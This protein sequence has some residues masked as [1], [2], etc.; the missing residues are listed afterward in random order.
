[1]ENLECD[2]GYM[3]SG[4]AIRGAIKKYGRE[5]FK[6]EL[7]VYFNTLEEAYE[8]EAMI[9]NEFFITRKDTYNMKCGGL[10][11]G[12]AG[13]NSPRYGK[14]HSDETKQK[15]S[16]AKK[17]KSLS[18]ETKAKMSEAKTGE[19]HPFF[20]KTHSDKTKQKISK[21]KKGVALPEEHKA[22]VVARAKNDP[23]RALS[24]LVLKDGVIIKVKNLRRFCREKGIAYYSNFFRKTEM[25]GYTLIGK[26]M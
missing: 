11:G 15:I 10:G 17:G 1:M 22:K 23:N 19:K 8:V 6:K 2:D 21:A 4:N 14:H 18:E 20:G 24:W 26:E 7:L 5:N 3:G 16:E 13:G 12:A 9:V 25:N